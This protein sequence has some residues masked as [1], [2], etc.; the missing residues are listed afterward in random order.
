MLLFFGQYLN[1]QFWF[2]IFWMIFIILLHLT[3]GSWQRN[4][5]N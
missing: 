5:R 1:V 4:Q 3:T 2:P